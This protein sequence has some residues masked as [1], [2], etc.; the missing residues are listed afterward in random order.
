MMTKK[1]L[2]MSAPE[3]EGNNEKVNVGVR[4]TNKTNQISPVISE[5]GDAHVGCEEGEEHPL[6]FKYVLQL[7]SAMLEH[8][9]WRP[10]H[11][12]SPCACLSLSPYLSV[13]LTACHTSCQTINNGNETFCTL[14]N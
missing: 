1:I 13:M 7:T 3:G 9:L 6:A 5:A 4:R 2:G 10:T 8:V 11:K 14:H 12:A